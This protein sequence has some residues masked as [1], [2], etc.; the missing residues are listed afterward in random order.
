MSQENKPSEEDLQPDAN[1]Q[2]IDELTDP[3]FEEL[4]DSSAEGGDSELAAKL[5]SAEQE[6]LRVRAE[7]ENYRKRVQRDMDSQLKYS[8]APL[9]RDLIEAVDNLNR[10]LQATT[11]GETNVKALVDGVQMVSQQFAGIF[12]KYGCKSIES[13]GQVFDP[14]IHEAIAQ[15][16]NPEVP[17]GKI[18]QEVAVGY[19]LHDRVIRPS[20]VIVSSGSGSA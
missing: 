17:A 20:Q 19:V 11:V 12:T 8:N 5:R 7:L 6:V 2:A 18:S 16:P 14:N 4:A 9:L 1:E 15:L 3:V 13:V 10:A